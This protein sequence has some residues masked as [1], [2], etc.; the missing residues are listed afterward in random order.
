[1]NECSIHKV[2]I[3]DASNMSNKLSGAIFVRSLDFVC[4]RCKT[5]EK[6]IVSAMLFEV[7]YVRYDVINQRM[8][9]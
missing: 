2:H 5:I 1:M 3:G 7:E 4:I 8:Q 9:S 6:T